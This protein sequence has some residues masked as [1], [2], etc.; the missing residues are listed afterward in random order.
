M[1]EAVGDMVIDHPY[2][3]HEGVAD[4]R[5]NELETPLLQVPAHGVGSG[6]LRGYI[7][8]TGPL[9]LDGPVAHEA[10]YITV[11]RTELFHHAEE[12]PGI[13]YCCEDL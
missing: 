1:S 6:G 11:K 7:A 5:A 2:R 12:S 9:I 13:L 3:L 8:R 10:P 4:C